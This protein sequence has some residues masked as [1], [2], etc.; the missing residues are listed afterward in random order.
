M[1]MVYKT[2]MARHTLRYHHV[3]TISG[4]AP[5]NSP[6]STKHR[7]THLPHHAP[8]AWDQ[9]LGVGKSFGQ[10]LRALAEEKRRLVH[11]CLPIHHGKQSSRSNT[12]G[13]VSKSTQLDTMRDAVYSMATMTTEISQ[14][15][16]YACFCFFG[17]YASQ[18]GRIVYYNNSQSTR[19]PAARVAGRRIS[20]GRTAVEEY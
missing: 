13:R 6:G 12:A 11:Y 4:P 20:T 16:V 19:T 18:V 5:L 1:H 15:G 9:P 17:P 7:S 8:Q 2:I 3:Y 10:R 14:G